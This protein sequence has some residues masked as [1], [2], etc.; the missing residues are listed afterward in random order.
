MES[1][2]RALEQFDA[3]FPYPHLYAMGQPRRLSPVPAYA[4][5]VGPGTDAVVWKVCDTNETVEL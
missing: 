4:M 1:L 5:R 3:E 2:M